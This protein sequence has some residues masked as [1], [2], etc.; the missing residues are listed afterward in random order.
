MFPGAYN[1][2]D[3]LLFVLFVGTQDRLGASYGHIDSRFDALH[4]G[5]NHSD[6]R[7]DHGTGS[8]R[9][10]VDLR[11]KSSVTR[12]SLDQISGC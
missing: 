1:I 8:A 3:D 10:E 12:Q 2:F 6:C 9:I 7:I 5:G 4:R 11:D